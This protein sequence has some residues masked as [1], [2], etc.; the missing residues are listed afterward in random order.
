MNNIFLIICCAFL[1]SG[2]IALIAKFFDIQPEIYLPYVFWVFA[3]GLFFIIL[4]KNKENI[5]MKNV[6]NF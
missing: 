3:L 4:D 6:K 1:I 2:S 5:F